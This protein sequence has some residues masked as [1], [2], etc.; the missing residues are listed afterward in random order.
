M[1]VKPWIKTDEYEGECRRMANGTQKLI[2][3]LAISACGVVFIGFMGWMTNM[4]GKISSLDTS[5]TTQAITSASRMSVLET[6]VQTVNVRLSRMEG[7]LDQLVE[8]KR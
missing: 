2:W 7:K 1:T 5:L 8:R 6:V 4:N 3:T